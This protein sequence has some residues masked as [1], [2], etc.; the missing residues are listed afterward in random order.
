MNELTIDE[1]SIDERT[2][3]E[4]T[5]NESNEEHKISMNPAME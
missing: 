1:Q 5:I 2:I 4:R 3:N